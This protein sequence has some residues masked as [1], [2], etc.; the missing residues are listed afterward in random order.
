MATTITASTS[1]VLVSTRATSNIVYLP[2]ISTVGNLIT[3][4]DNDGFAS[5]Q[6]PI[7][8][9]TTA[10]ASFLDGSTSLS[11]NQPF[12]FITLQ[13]QENGVYAIVNTFAFQTGQSAASVNNLVTSTIQLFDVDTGVLNTMYSSNSQLMLNDE[14]LGTVT[15]AQ[16]TS[17]VQGLGSIGYL[18]SLSTVVAIPPIWI[19]VGSGSNSTYFNPGPANLDKTSSIMYSH[20]GFNWTSAVNGFS[21]GGTAV[22]YGAP[23]TG[24]PPI[25][26]A[27]GYDLDYPNTGYG[28]G[29][30]W[31]PDGIN[32]NTVSYEFQYIYEPR[33]S[34][35]YKNGIFLAGGGA[36]LDSSNSIVWSAD[37]SN[38]SAADVAGFVQNT[39]QDI[40]WG[41][42]VWVAANN[43]SVGLDAGPP[44]AL[45]WSKDGSNWNLADTVSWTQNNAYAV[46][47]DGTKFLANVDGGSNFYSPNLAYS[48]NGSNWTSDG[49]LG[50]VFGTF[51]AANAINAGGLACATPVP[52]IPPGPPLGSPPPVL[53]LTQL[54]GPAPIWYSTDG[55]FSWASDTT[56][57]THLGRFYKPYYDGSKWWVG[58]VDQ[59]TTGVRMAYSMDGKNWSS[60][61]IV[62]AFSN[63]T[64]YGSPPTGA[65][66][67]YAV[68]GG[69]NANAQLISTVTGLG[70]TFQT[71]SF[72]TSTL[73]VSSFLQ[74]LSV[75]QPVPNLWVSVGNGGS[76]LASIQT[77]KT[78][79]NW[80]AIQTGGFSN[81]G[82]GVCY[83]GIQWVSVGNQ[84]STKLG[85]IQTS[86]DGSNWLPNTSGGFASL[87][88]SIATDGIIFLAGGDNG[89]S[90]LG[91][92]QRSTDGFT[93]SSNINGGFTSCRSVAWNGLYWLATGSNTSHTASIQTSQDGFTWSP[94][95]S[96]G[97]SNQGNG[98]AWSGTLWAAVGN[99]GSTRSSIQTSKDGLNWSAI[100]TGGFPTQGN[101]V[102]YNGFLWVAVGSNT[103][104]LGTIQTSSNGVQWSNIV[105]GGFSNQGFGIAWNG[106]NW[107]AVGD[108][109]S[110]RSSI[111]ISQD[112]SNWSPIQTGGFS[113]RGYGVSYSEP[114]APDITTTGLAFYTA[115]QPITTRTQQN[116]QNQHQI[117]TNG[118]I[119][120][121][122]STL[123]INNINQSVGINTANPR[124]A[125]DVNGSVNI[126]GALTT[127]T[128][129]ISYVSSLG[130][131]FSGYF[132]LYYNPTNGTIGYAS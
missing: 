17:T 27:V 49:L 117:R 37:G 54:Q 74:T 65:F 52:S 68:G 100:Q 34:C 3:V 107:I 42:G 73:Q 71:S 46:L 44:G 20:D 91:S 53:L 132:G 98:L 51:P 21:I 11:I 95:V 28:K 12:G 40:T 81:A 75:Q 77:S 4:R 76:K 104:G 72:Q 48:Y 93:W 101:G 6:S 61:N 131:S 47:F 120:S 102:A 24:G 9:T 43:P 119:L 29:I 113:Q 38:W 127:S 87:G 39:V 13:T 125:L 45:L 126:Q 50:P 63:S 59:S 32:W 90:Q 103:T 56:F 129:S 31:S 67:F 124:T 19:S 80:S 108:G 121:I 82:Y 128:L 15:D 62:G 41:N 109:G 1:V 111:Q 25:Y 112:G 35:V 123:F 78:G 88:Y 79:S 30:R 7:L 83:N 114:Y 22:T 115:N 66:G 94:L 16:L 97:F 2:N 60:D 33:T 18:S 99:G 86:I 110:S 70:Q 116:T 85:S 36:F 5:V 57:L 96:G 55:G 58:Y 105:S 23:Q 8:L 92:I 118:P 10:N 89:T 69:S 26:V 84:N 64:P 130:G 106:V 122:D 14:V